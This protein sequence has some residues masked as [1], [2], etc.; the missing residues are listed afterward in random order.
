MNAVIP[1]ACEGDV[2]AFVRKAVELIQKNQ[3]ATLELHVP[4]EWWVRFCIDSFADS[5]EDVLD[6]E[7]I[8][9]GDDVN[10]DVIF[11]VADGSGPLDLEIG[12]ET[13]N[14]TE[15]SDDEI[16]D[17]IDRMLEDLDEENEDNNNE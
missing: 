16:Q 5:V 2:E 12:G 6:E 3:P 4:N 8:P 17:L 11:K 15:L 10:V 13:L 9:T 1:I 14:I 7:D